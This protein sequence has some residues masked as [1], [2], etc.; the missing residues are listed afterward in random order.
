MTRTEQVNRRLGGLGDIGKFI[1]ALWR[2]RHSGGAVTPNSDATK[3]DIAAVAAMVDGVD[4]PV[5]VG[6]AETAV[7][8]TG[9]TPTIVTTST[10]FMKVLVTVKKAGTHGIYSGAKVASQALAVKPAV[11]AAEC[12]IAY[13]EIP[14][15]FTAG[16]TSVT[17][18]MCKQASA[19]DGLGIF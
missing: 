19:V 1:A 3:I 11:P 7:V 6:V 8:L 4:V 15:S 5:G 18:G 12:E 17:A 2:S 13:L 10:Q 14:N 16:T 9:Y